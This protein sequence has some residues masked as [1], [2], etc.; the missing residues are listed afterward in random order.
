MFTS[1]R[2]AQLYDTINLHEEDTTFYLELAD[3]LRPRDVL[4][5]GCGTG[6]LA[7][8]LAEQGYRVTGVDPSAPM[9]ADARAKPNPGDVR[10]VEGGAEQL[11]EA[12]A[13]LVFMTGH[14]AQFFVADDDW[15]DALRRINRALRPGG[16]LA[17]ET[18]NPLTRPWEQGTR[19][20]SLRTVETPDGLL[21]TWYEVRSVRNH[22]VDYVVSYLFPGGERVDDANILVFR[23][24]REIEASLADAGFVLDRLYGD[25]DRSAVTAHCPELIYVAQSPPRAAY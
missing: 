10:W 13:D 24:R 11:G 8:L 4:D 2:L 15:S 5:L 12:E 14:V 7:L 1:D 3:E 17:F 16:W 25:W 6:R 19:E 22:R 20:K 9:L 23:D 18:R 21:E